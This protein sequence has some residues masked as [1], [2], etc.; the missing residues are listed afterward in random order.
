MGEKG[1]GSGGDRRRSRRIHR[2]S[3]REDVEREVESHIAL[4]AEELEGAG[5]S[6]AE[7]RAEAE[8]LFG[9]RRSVAERAREE[10]RVTRR[11]KDRASML[12][13]VWRDV[14]H[15]A[16]SLGRNPGFAVVAILTLA[17]GIGANTAVFTAVSGVLLAEPPYPDPGE[18]VVLWERGD[19]GR[20]IPVSWPNFVDWR[21]TAGSFEAMATLPGASLQATV[22]A[23]AEAVR[24][25]VDPVGAD[26]FATL[27][28]PPELGRVFGPEESRPGQAPVAVVSH[29]FWRDVLGGPPE[30][31]GVTVRAFGLTAEVVGVMPAGFDYP[32]GA[33]VWIPGEQSED[34]SSR[35]AH[36]YRVVGRLADGVSLEAARSEMSGLAARLREEH[37]AEDNDAVDAIVRPLREERAGDSGRALLLLLGAAGL[38]LLIA[39]ANIASALLARGTARVR[40]TAV[41]SA[42]GAGGGRVVRQL[43]T[44]N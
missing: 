43:V 35:T 30:L 9:D 21:R 33:D 40:E 22:L 4:R 31:D 44:E 18:L 32:Y 16:R 39:C 20:Q 12:E 8:R 19:A 23:G 25:Q 17:L 34:T 29:G 36:N 27:G 6:A 10:A 42:L 24:A 1:R 28:V 11:R 2:L 13:A 37:G 41:R 38:V 26:F 5:W 15:G 14:R 3:V 7:A